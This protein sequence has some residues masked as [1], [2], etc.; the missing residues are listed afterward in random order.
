MFEAM[1]EKA[2]RICEAKFATVLFEGAGFLS[3]ASLVP[4]ELRAIH[5]RAPDRAYRHSPVLLAESQRAKQVV[6]VADIAAEPEYGR[7]GR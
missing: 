1:L 7:V 2:A 5:A 6:H 3:V 4:H